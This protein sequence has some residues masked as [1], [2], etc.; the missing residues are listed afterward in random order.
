PDQ[1]IAFEPLL[2]LPEVRGPIPRQ[3]GTLGDVCV[4]AWLGDT[5]TAGVC[6]RFGAC[7][8]GG[9]PAPGSY[10]CGA[11]GNQDAAPDGA[12]GSGGGGGTNR[13][14]GAG[15]GG[16]AEAGDA[17]PSEGAKDGCD[18]SLPGRPSGETSRTWALLLALAAI[19][20]GRRRA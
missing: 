15:I 19:A 16:A 3:V 7:G 1:P 10:V 5:D 17:S 13:P 20:R 14:D 8:D 11:S 2:K 6:R 18:C 4:S 9:L 12:G